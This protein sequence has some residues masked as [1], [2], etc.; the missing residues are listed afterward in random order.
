[1]PSDYFTKQDEEFVYGF[2]S[3]F[4]T[5]AVFAT[6]WLKVVCRVK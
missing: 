4:V 6:L 5:G 1:M 3:G 2:V